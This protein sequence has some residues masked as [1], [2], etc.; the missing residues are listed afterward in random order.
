MDPY[1]VLPVLMG[2]SMYVMQK[3]QP[4][5][6]QDPMQQKIMQYMPVAFSV[7]MAWFPSGLVLYWFISNLISITQMKIIFSGIEKKKL[8]ADQAKS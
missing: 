4:M 6:V 7:F 8:A 1:Y 2:I 5:T 3:L